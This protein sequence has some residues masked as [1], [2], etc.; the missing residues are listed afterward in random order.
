MA[1]SIQALSLLQTMHA[2]RP[3]GFLVQCASILQVKLY[4]DM[5]M[6][7]HL[8]IGFIPTVS[9]KVSSYDID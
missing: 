2:T 9:A 8:S 6:S 4:W 1:V 5:T 7:C 3:G